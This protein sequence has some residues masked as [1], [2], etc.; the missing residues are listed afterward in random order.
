MNALGA[1]RRRR[2]IFALAMAAALAVSVSEAMAYPGAHIHVVRPSETLASI[3]THYYGDPRREMI[4]VS[5]NA[6]T[7]QGGSDIVVGLRL[8]VPSVR[9]HR[10]EEGE[11][12]M[13]IAERYYGDGTRAFVLTEA[14]GG[15]GPHPDV[16]AE[17]LIP[18]PLR[19]V[20]GQ[21]ETLRRIAQQYYGDDRREYV[22]R[23]RRFNGLRSV[24]VTRGRVVLVPLADLVLTDEGRQTIAEATGSE[25]EGGRVRALQQQIDEQLPGLRAHV[26]GGRYAEAVALANRLLGAGELTGNQLVSIQRELG[27]AYVAL[28]RAD[29]AEEAF[30]AAIERQPDLE[31]DSTRTSPTVLR[32]FRRAKSGRA[33]TD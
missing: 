30:A 24:R 23:L 11:T 8:L 25:V 4:L 33:A 16:G 20:S 10:V 6:L 31:L 29:L 7:A 19:H 14:N 26:H 9:H 15:T 22:Q 13:Q 1:T 2:V 28:G 3:A 12:W 21:N 32:A 18:Y 17:L 27:T 5:E